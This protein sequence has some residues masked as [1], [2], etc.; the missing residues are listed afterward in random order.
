MVLDLTGEFS[1][2]RPFRALP[3][4]NLPVLDLTAP[5]RDDL[6]AGVEFI[7]AHRH[8]GAVYVHCK[9]GYSRSAVVVASWLM[10]VGDATTPDEALARIRTVRPS[11]VIR[12]EIICALRHSDGT[13]EA[14]NR[15]VSSLIEVRS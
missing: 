14:V 3:Y 9:I 1:E 6:R 12:P 2:T 11:C 7:N 10:D 13:D 4:L 8:Q 15:A 5:S